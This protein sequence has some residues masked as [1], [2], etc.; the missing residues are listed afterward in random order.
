[1]KPA[2]P[3]RF[4]QSASSTPHAH[5]DEA[6]YYAPQASGT[7]LETT[8]ELRS[9]TRRPEYPGTP[10][11]SPSPPPRELR[12]RGR[13]AERTARRAYSVPVRAD[14]VDPRRHPD[15]VILPTPPGADAH[16]SIEGALLTEA[17]QRPGAHTAPRSRAHSNKPVNR[18]GPVPVWYRAGDDGFALLRMEDVPA[19]EP[20]VLV[21]ELAHPD[22]VTPRR[23]DWPDE[24]CYLGDVRVT[25]EGYRV[26]D[27][28][29]NVTVHEDQERMHKE[30]EFASRLLN[31]ANDVWDPDLFVAA[32]RA[33]LD[34]AR[35]AWEIAHVRF[36]QY[37][38]FCFAQ[39][40]SRERLLILMA[41]EHLAN[42][43]LAL[44]TA[45]DPDEPRAPTH[46]HATEAEK[47]RAWRWRYCG[48]VNIAAQLRLGCAF[49]H[50]HVANK[51]DLL[52][53][54]WENAQLWLARD[55]GE[56]KIGISAYS[57]ALRN[58]KSALSRSDPAK[59]R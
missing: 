35:M 4:A 32:K 54:W 42:G 10:E 37:A 40:T 51:C 22:F 45:V 46:P 31:R 28:T 44:A 9:A 43:L 19:G 3:A 1:M 49:A 56:R 16:F 11:R 33:M 38:E 29:R 27:A 55:A 17:W 30:M 18:T 14:S 6:W 39:S 53:R 2:T 21:P 7:S 25:P 20:E 58:M 48:N 34:A 26:Y 23:A 36:E 5:G 47:R 57:L 24:V 52:E 41:Y 12:N 50:P 13:Q 8:P 15:A 59:R